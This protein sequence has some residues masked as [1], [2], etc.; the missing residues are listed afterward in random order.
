[1]PTGDVPT[2]PSGSAVS[3]REFGPFRID[4]AERQLFR[5]GAE[6]PL[7]AKVFDIL[8]VLVLSGGRT[9][10]KEEFMLAV[11]P[12]A[13]VEES[14]L[15]DNIS[16]L[17]QILGDDAREPK[18]IKT[19][20][21][22]GY[23]FVAA[24]R[25]RAPA[26]N[27]VREGASEPRRSYVVQIAVSSV[28]AVAIAALLIFRSGA[29][30]DQ[31]QTSP[32]R[33][34]VLPFKP[35]VAANRDPALELGITDALISKLSNIRQITVRP[36]SAVLSYT[37]EGQDLRAIATELDVD[38]LIDGKVQKSGDRVRLSVQM[39]RAAD[40]VPMWAHTFDEKVTDLFAVQDAISAKAATALAVALSA[41]EKTEVAKRPTEDVEAYQLYMKGRYL[42]RTFSP[43]SVEASVSHYEAAI[44]RDPQFALAYAGLADSYTILGIYGP[45]TPKE[46]APKARAASAKAIA[47]DPNLSGAHL[48]SGA[49]KLFF[50]WDWEGARVAFTRA[51]ELD[52][53]NHDAHTLYGYY[54]QTQDRHDEALQH[55][56]RT[57][58]LVPE[59]SV[60]NNDVFRGLQ[61]ARRYDEAIAHARRVIQL[62][63][64]NKTAHVVLAQ[65][66]A[67]KGLYGEA[68]AALSSVEAPVSPRSRAEWYG[69]IAYAHAMMGNRAEAMKQL[70]VLK[71]IP[72]VMTPACVASV[73]SGLGDKDRAFS[74]LERAYEERDPFIWR[75]R[76]LPQFD[77]LRADP[78]WAA[79]MGRLKLR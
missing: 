10:T 39:V 70:E 73:Y 12:D 41:N 77:A 59:W 53:N 37:K 52:P 7:T 23:R 15:T 71:A 61:I 14:N 29:P 63:P 50:D 55:L 38:A 34:A 22:R 16:T 66:L 36:T 58:D 62:E 11:W 43:A 6:I 44:A 5:D 27:S 60:A 4:I 72:S 35:L 19:V 32:R 78:R 26:V 45:L 67:G 8:R 40:G 21:K 25:E 24:V 69:L 47:L 13:V 79:L 30:H 51:M 65:S 18:Y 64:G 57:R 20:P 2:E 17:R 31:K 54:L 46:A 9:I 33:V 3:S 76:T 74:A 28:V 42:W 56:R 48:G 1:M 68:L 49:G 75:I